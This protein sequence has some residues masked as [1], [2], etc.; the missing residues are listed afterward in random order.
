M[1]KVSQVQSGDQNYKDFQLGLEIQYFYGAL[2][3]KGNY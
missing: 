1:Q 2:H 3:V